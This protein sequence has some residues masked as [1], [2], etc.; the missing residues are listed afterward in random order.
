MNINSLKILIKSLRKLHESIIYA[1]RLIQPD[2][3]TKNNLTAYK[4]ICLQQIALAAKCEE[5]VHN[6]DWPQASQCIAKIDHLAE[7][8]KSDSE[9]LLDPD[10]QNRQR[11]GAC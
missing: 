7:M 8:I 3:D 4:E 9:Y 5:Y 10:E 6:S 1:E 11:A 2:S